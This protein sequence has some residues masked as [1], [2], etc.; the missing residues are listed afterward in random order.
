MA[1]QRSRGG[2]AWFWGALCAILLILISTRG[3]LAPSNEALHQVF[4]AQPPPPGLDLQALL[5]NFDLSQL[6]PSLQ[7]PARDLLANLGT[8]QPGVPVEATVTTPR[9]RVTVRELR[10]ILGNLLVNG[11]VTN[12]SQYDVVVPLSVFVLQDSTGLSYRI[13]NDTG[14]PLRPGERIPLDLSIPLPPGRGLLLTTNFPPD[15]P[16][17]QRLIVIETP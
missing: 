17:T 3:Q 2:P 14:I 16:V 15:A 6:P 13:G 8:G 4:A 10:P 7:T 1:E 9:L 11:E 5:P 12:V